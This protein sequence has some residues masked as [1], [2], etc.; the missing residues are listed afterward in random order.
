LAQDN[1]LVKSTSAVPTNAKVADA[2]SV[3]CWQYA[4]DGTTCV[5][6][7]YFH[8]DNTVVNSWTST[9]TSTTP[10]FGMWKEDA[11]LSNG[12]LSC[13][14][15][16]VSKPGRGGGYLIGGHKN[17]LRKIVP[18]QTILD[19]QGNPITSVIDHS[20]NLFTLNQANGTITGTLGTFPAYYLVGDIMQPD[21]FGTGSTLAYGSCARCHTTGYRF[22]ANGP[23][24]TQVTLGTPNTYT[25]L[26]DAQ[27]S[28]IP[29][30]GASGTTSSWFLT[31]I[32]CERCHKADMQYDATS[33]NPAYN[34]G[35]SGSPNWQPTNGRISH[36]V[37]IQSPANTDTATG[38]IPGTDFYLTTATST[39][40]TRPHPNPPT[41]L[42]CVECHQAY[43]TWTAKTAGT[44]GEVHTLPLPGF[45]DL[46]PK[47][48]TS[49]F[50]GTNPTGEFTATF[51]CSVAGQTTFTGCVNAGGTVTYAPGG[52]S[53]GVV[54][55]LL[56]SPHGLVTGYVDKK[57]QGTG[58]TT[59][60][61]TGGTLSNGITVK[62]QYNTFFSSAGVSDQGLPPNAG[63]NG[64]QGSCAGCHNIH[65]SL[66]SYFEPEVNATNVETTLKSCTDCH[67]S[68][69]QGMAHP[70]G[71]GTPYPSG[72]YGDQESCSI[73]HLG[74]V[75]GTEYHFLRIN[76]DVN[77]TTFPTAQ[78]YYTTYGS[79]G[80]GKLNTYN[81]GETYKD[82]A[83]NTQNYPAVALDVDITCGQ[84]HIGG[85]GDKNVNGG[86]NPYGIAPGKPDGITPPVF[87]RA[88]L[89]ATAVNMHNTNAAAPTFSPLAPYTGAPTN[90]TISSTSSQEGSPAA[91][92]YTIDGTTP[93]VVVGPTA[94]Y[95]PGNTNTKQCANPC[96]VNVTSSTTINALAAGAMSYAF[97]PSPVVGGYFTIPQTSKPTINPTGGTYNY[98]ATAQ[99]IMSDATT[100]ASIFYTTDGSTPTA[101]S[102]LYT[103]PISVVPGTIKAIAT[104]SGSSTSLV[105]GP[106]TF[107]VK[108]PA[109]SFSTANGGKYPG[110]YTGS[111]VVNPTNADASAK[112]CYTTNGTTPAA[113]A[114]VCTTGTLV[115]AGSTFTLN[116]P[117]TFMVKVMAFD[118]SYTNSVVVNATYTIK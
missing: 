21:V 37:N 18:G 64:V 11:G 59:L 28:R 118:G 57:V 110:T 111:A 8:G 88:F 58:D 14:H 12:C 109:P 51:G 42:T 17:I 39:T 68:H 36:L 75:S 99:I 20:S 89:A 82:A 101:S 23:E 53:H 22:D 78:T 69:G 41:A 94:A 43:A 63:T 54:T 19:T 77:Y 7:Q 10:A 95:I 3:D 61:I 86:G 25:K 32:Q 55:T 108:L 81:S 31:G 27:F 87:T 40:G 104:A 30:G 52:M 79:K 96:T 49:K 1:I 67:S 56:N 74:K 102:T 113:A 9:A 46:A 34:A 83:G 2:A 98:G 91:I 93:N 97:T 60:T 103:G 5:G 26:T 62:G 4:A 16:D 115:N 47:I 66:D 112:F 72:N 114:G 24:P 85:N 15:G 76:P 73:C 35:T 84:C 45:E 70:T 100:G 116:T 44:V 107:I 33:V 38:K 106:A 90:V 48:D 13:H 6:G 92:F 29:A 80:Y 117:G 71:P 50:T 65:G 105:A